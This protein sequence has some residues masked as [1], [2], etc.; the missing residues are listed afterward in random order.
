MVKNLIVIVLLLVVGGIKAQSQYVFIDQKAKSVP[1]HLKTYQEI[2][3]HLTKD[4]VSNKQKVRALYVW[5]AH[6]VKYDIHKLN[7]KKIRSTSEEIIRY[8]L[9]NR[10]GLCQHYAELFSAISTSIGIKY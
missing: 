4:L 5:I 8:V 2:A 3:N 7:I 6:N 1:N 10:K 9:S